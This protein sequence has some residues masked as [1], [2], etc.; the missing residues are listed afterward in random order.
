MRRFAGGLSN[1]EYH[2]LLALAGEALY[3]Y[4]ITDAVVEES[5]ETLKPRAGSLY[6]VLSR[7][8]TWGLIEEVEPPEGDE[9]HPG[10]SRRWYAL[11]PLG[12]ETLAETSSRLGHVAALARRK[13][14]LG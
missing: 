6:R 2:V 13:L 14:R 4:A 7:L 12:R 8:M 10:R 9:E 3:G 1:L 11:T 5:A